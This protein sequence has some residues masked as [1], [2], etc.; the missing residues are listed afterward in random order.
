MKA[1]IIG[2]GV[3]GLSAGCY[4][5]MN[6][7]A[8]GIYEQHSAP[9]GLCTSWK[10]GDYTFGSGFQWL[11]GSSPASPFYQLWSELLDMDSLTF[12]QH[13]VRMEIEVKTNRDINGSKIF[14]LYTNLARL[15][16]YML[17]IAPEDRVPILRLIQTMRKIQSYEI[18]PAI[19]SNPDI[20]PLM[21]KIGFIRYLP[22]LLFMNRIKRRPTFPLRPNLRTLS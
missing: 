22:L 13:E 11:L 5:Q 14:H 21:K 9:G 18:P 3:S 20:L 15:E 19:R 6:G 8:T 7:F 12:I 17:D 4:L 1:A 16:R 2:S 10:R